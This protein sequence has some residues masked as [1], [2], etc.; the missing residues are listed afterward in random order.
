MRGDFDLERLHFGI[1][2]VYE[3][4]EGK[5]RALNLSYLFYTLG[6]I[7]IG[8]VS[9]L[10]ILKVIDGA[11]A[12]LLSTML[13]TAV[14]ISCIWHTFTLLGKYTRDSIRLQ[15]ESFSNLTKAVS[16]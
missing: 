12:P 16:A 6:L 8:S 7:V 10:F 11:V 9:G 15:E 5:V 4:Y 3:D 13:M 14:L 1:E 2:E